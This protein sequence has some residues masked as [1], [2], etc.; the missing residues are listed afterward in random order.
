MKS[1]RLYL[2]LRRWWWLLAVAGALAAISSIVSLRNIPPTYRAT[3]TLIIGQTLENP[4]PNSGDFF[5]GQQLSSIYA[6]LAMREPIQEAVRTSLGLS[7][8]PENSVLAVL[9]NQLIE[10][11]VT[12]TSPERAQT[13]ANEL[14]RQIILQ[15]PSSLE[16][17]DQVRAEFVTNQLDNLQTIITKTQTEIA[18]LQFRM[19]E[20]VSASDLERT[21]EAQI[22][23]QEKLFL[24]Q[25]NYANLLA[26][27]RSGASNTLRVFE[28]ALLPTK[29]IGPDRAVIV[30]LATLL[31]VALGGSGMYLVE[32]F[33][34]RL[35]TPEEI[36]AALQ[37]PII[38]FIP[39]SRLLRAS[40]KGYD[41][42]TPLA[43]SSQEALSFELLATNLSFRFGESPPRSLLVTSLKPGAGK[44]TVAAHLAIQ[45]ALRGQ[46][47]TL[48][49]AD[50]RDPDL[51]RRFGA[52]LYPGLGD[53]LQESLTLKTITQ[54]TDDA[55]LKI[56][57]S[58]A[59]RDDYTQVFQPA[60]VVRLL[61][62]LHIK[63][64]NL[65]VIDSPPVVVPE[66]LLLASKVDAVLLVIRPGEIDQ[67]AASILMDQLQQSHGNILGIVV[68]RIP[69]YMVSSDGITP[70]LSQ[71][72]DGGK[73]ISAE[74]DGSDISEPPQEQLPAF[75][76]EEGDK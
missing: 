6:S 72:R 5:L 2:H 58:G 63:K 4:N 61:A 8:L 44:T 32:F 62:K 17:E 24:F 21:R 20:M 14:A 55:R 41:V 68:N 9:D 26:N 3:S 53:A 52:E 57:T 33:D 15:S 25:T 16:Q 22:A 48:V 70:Y 11:S 43:I 39:D 65:A 69:R 59:R 54:S 42:S 36:S 73:A 31:G 40:S 18:D 37:L 50:L 1:N 71:S 76:E 74:V 35:K 12:D 60:E 10:I 19:V 75:V 67:R 7:K 66:T 34:N 28:S 47:I 51:H 30:F 38:G 46:M 56:I 45:L 49:D 29:P 64:I 13:V 23:L 27:S